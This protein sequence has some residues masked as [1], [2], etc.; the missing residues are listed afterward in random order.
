MEHRSNIRSHLLPTPW[1]QEQWSTEATSGHICYQPLG[2]KNG[3]AQKQH[4]VTFATN[5]LEPRT[6]EHRS[7]IRS[8]LLLTPWSQERWS[9]EA[10]SGHICYQLLGAKNSG[11]QKQHQVT[12][13]TN[14]LEPRTVEHRS[15]IR[16]H[17][18]LTPWSQEQWSTEATSGHICYQLLGAKNSGAQ[19]QHQVTFAT[20]PL[21]PRTVEHRSNIRSHLLPTPWSQE[22]WSTE[23]TSGHICYQLLGA[24]NSGAQKQ[25]Q[26]TFATN[27]LEPR[28][29][30]HRSNIRS[31]LLPTPW[32]QEQ[33]STEAT[34]GHICYQLLG[35]KNSGSQKQHQVTFAT[36]PLEPRVEHRSNIRSHLLPT[37]WS[38]EQWST[39]AT[40][41][42]ICYQPL[43]AKNGGA[44]KQH[45]VTFA[46]N[47]L[48]PRT[49]EHRS[50]IR[51]HLLLTPWSQA[52]WSTEVREDENNHGHERLLRL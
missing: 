8:H 39:E 6:V 51:S 28:T 32:S 19:K 34:S 27:S 11:A 44:Q 45:Q 20:N 30:E 15:N 18:L 42:H 43:G 23:A 40:S 33:W 41:G 36:N 17:L 38:Q 4:Q 13:A 12:F 48:E 50:N 35:A 52:E 24:K 10:T 37:P 29:V 9:T 7:N 25:H 3:G 26:V 31:H 21:E 16:S 46:T 22:Q 5:S 14:S 1:S 2:A 47:S 49:L